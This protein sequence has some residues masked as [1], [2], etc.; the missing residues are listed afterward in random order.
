MKMLGHE[1][2]QILLA[3]PTKHWTL[4]FIAVCIISFA[5]VRDSKRQR[6]LPD[7]PIVGLAKGETIRQARERFRHDSKK[8]LLDGYRKVSLQS[9]ISTLELTYLSI[10]ENPSMFQRIWASAS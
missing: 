2:V 4:I 6:I 10:R 8:M 9:S 3:F 7:V 5:F 1:I